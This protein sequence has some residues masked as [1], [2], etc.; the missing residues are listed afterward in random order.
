MERST[1]M[2]VDYGNLWD[3]HAMGH[4][5][6]VTTNGFINQRGQLV[7]GRGCAQEAASKFPGIQTRLAK[8]VR[9]GGNH[10]YYVPEYN[11]FSFPVKRYYWNDADIELIKRSCGELM[12]QLGNSRVRL[13]LYMP[14][15]G[16][17]NGHLDWD[18]V[19]YDIKPLL[20]DDIVVVTF[21]EGD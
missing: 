21:A 20:S 4:T 8:L 16:C 15:P 5:I 13:P 3:Y 2:L 10:V 18:E 9:E 7:M 14:R 12:A 11:I 19:Y 17:G 6:A 1:L